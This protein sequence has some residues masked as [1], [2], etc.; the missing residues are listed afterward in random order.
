MKSIGILGGTFNPPHMGH[1]L[2]AEYVREE[3]KLDEIWFIPTN[4]PPHK[5]TTHITFEQRV[6]ML[7]GAIEDNPPFA[8]NMIEIT[9][10]GKS[11]TIDTI[12]ELKREYPTY[13]FYFI[14]GADMVEY[15]PHWSRIDELINEVDFVGVNRT[16]FKLESQYQVLTVDVPLIDISSSLIRQRFA[17]GKSIKYLVPNKVF[18]YIK[19]NRLYETNRNN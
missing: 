4:E 1:L 2:I 11:Y 16:G 5:A 8:I 12:K 6:E 18:S 14:I 15:L 3:L 10:P 7:S 17:S 9:R 13:T 19:E